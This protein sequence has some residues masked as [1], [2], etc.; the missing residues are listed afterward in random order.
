MDLILW[1]LV[2]W[3]FELT[4]QNFR[5][6]RRLIAISLFKQKFFPQQIGIGTFPLGFSIFSSVQPITANH[7][8]TYVA[9]CYYCNVERIVDLSFSLSL[10]LIFFP[11]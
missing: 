5:S 9:K 2:A 3:K 4:K 1:N 11:Y 8:P 10:F 6:V 7:R